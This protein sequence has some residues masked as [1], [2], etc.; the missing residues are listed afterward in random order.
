MRRVEINSEAA[1]IFLSTMLGKSQF[2]IER[3][4][5]L[6]ERLEV[7]IPEKLP[8]ENKLTKDGIV[9]CSD[10][11]CR[12]NFKIRWELR[13]RS[14]L[15]SS[16]LENDPIYQEIKQFFF[17]PDEAEYGIRMYLFANGNTNY[18]LGGGLETSFSLTSFDAP[19]PQKKSLNL[20]RRFTI[21]GPVNIKKSDF[22]HSWEEI[23]E[24]NRYFSQF[25]KTH[26]WRDGEVF[27]RA[28]NAFRYSKQ[29]LTNIDI[30]EKIYGGTYEGRKNL[31]HD[32]E[33]EMR[34]D[35][36]KIEQQIASVNEFLKIQMEEGGLE[37][38]L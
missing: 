17:L 30:M 36:I 32:K 28:I 29:E 34:R 5:K 31:L 35:R 20:I 19:E 21:T 38:F 6:R 3:R 14:R 27:E 37:N 4:E 23:Q 7:Q 16:S 1:Y 13:N 26:S 8:K 12:E 25:S 15:C 2:F 10:E 33:R 11:E 9:E 18:I 24:K 22:D